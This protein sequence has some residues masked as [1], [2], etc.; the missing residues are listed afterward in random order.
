MKKWLD[1]LLARAHRERRP[2]PARSTFRPCLEAL[3]DRNLMNVSTVF[4][5]AGNRTVLLVAQDGS[6]LE[7]TSSTGFNPMVLTTSG[8]RVAHAFLDSTGAPAFDIIY[9]SGQAFEYD[10]TGGHFMGPNILDM[11]RVVDR[12]GNFKLDV[13]FAKTGSSPPFSV[14]LTGNLYEYTSTSVTQLSTDAR[15][16]SNYVDPN[17]GLGIAVG[18]ISGGNLVAFRQDSTGSFLLYNSPDGAT[19]DITDYGQTTDPISGAVWSVVTHGRF[20]GTYAIEYRP[21]GAVTIGSGFDILV[22]G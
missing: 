5:A 22:G 17:G 21:T 13:L 15:W 14:D 12:H 20:A 18:L 6:L 7:Y 3:E 16:V 10:S 4:D 9:Q 8:I 11:S 2:A 1:N 19:Q